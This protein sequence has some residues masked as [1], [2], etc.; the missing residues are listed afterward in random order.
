VE[1]PVVITGAFHARFIDVLFPITFDAWTFVTTGLPVVTSAVVARPLVSNV[2][3]KLGVIRNLN[4]LPK[5]SP[6]TVALVAVDAVRWKTTQVIPSLE[7][8][9]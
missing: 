2:A 3:L 9:I 5:E 4:V 1:R 6:V 7:T 8:S